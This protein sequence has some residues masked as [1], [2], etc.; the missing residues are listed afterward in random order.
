[1][2]LFGG[3]YNDCPRAQS[4]LAAEANL[5]PECAEERLCPQPAG[6]CA[7]VLWPTRPVPNHGIAGNIDTGLQ[8]VGCGSGPLRPVGQDLAHNDRHWVGIDDV[9]DLVAYDTP[10]PRHDDAASTKKSVILA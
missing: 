5:N 6:E 4:P 2:L 7:G 9:L 1:V 3:R 8:K 10:T